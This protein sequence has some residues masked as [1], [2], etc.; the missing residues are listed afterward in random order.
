MQQKAID[1]VAIV[2]NKAS[3]EQST[4]A[5]Q[6]KLAALTTAITGVEQLTQAG[7]DMMV[8][9]EY[10]QAATALNTSTT[11]GVAFAPTAG[12]LSPVTSAASG[13][14][15][16]APG[17]GTTTTPAET[18]ANTPTGTNL[19]TGINTPTS[20]GDGGNGVTPAA[21]TPGQPTPA[22]GGGNP[23]MADSMTPAAA[24]TP[25]AQPK[26]ADNGR[27]AMAYGGGGGAAYMAGGVGADKS[28]NLA[29]LLGQLLPKKDEKTASAD[30]IM[31]F[32]G[33]RDPASVNTLLGRNVNLF[34]RIED[35]MQANYRRGTVGL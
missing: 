17:T 34:K 19:G 8:A 32:A 4:V 11:T 16:V 24:E 12:D 29:G 3:S 31:N 13:G 9:D 35:S 33:G 26:S 1:G 15:A 10:K 5:S 23:A 2:A 14:T 28:D 18:P 22:S 20:G 21:F 30:G 6:A 27:Q 7:V 25:E